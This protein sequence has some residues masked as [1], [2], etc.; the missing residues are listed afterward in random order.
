MLSIL[1]ARPRDYFGAGFT[2]TS[3][4]TGAL[5]FTSVNFSVVTWF[6]VAW[7]TVCATLTPPT[8]R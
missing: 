7:R 4:A 5:I 3:S 6:H 1:M 2:N 8:S